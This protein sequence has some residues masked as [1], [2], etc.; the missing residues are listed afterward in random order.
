MCKGTGM[1]RSTESSEGSRAI[2]RAASG[3]ANETLPWYLK[4]QMACWSGG[5]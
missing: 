2:M 3:A 1:I 5:V 4:R